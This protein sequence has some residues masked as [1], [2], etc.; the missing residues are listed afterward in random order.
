MSDRDPAGNLTDPVGNLTE[1][2]ERHVTPVAL[3][4]LADGVTAPW[5]FRAAGVTAGLKA[6]GK[7]DVAVVI[8]DQPCTAAAVL[9]TNQVKAAPVVVT[10]D[11]LVSSGGVA[12]A[13]LLN[14]GSANVCCGQPG[15]DLARQAAELTATQIGCAAEQVLVCSTGVIGVPVPATPY[16][17]AIPR[18]V[19]AASPEG[20][21]DAAEAIMTTDLV[22]KEA[23]VHVTDSEG[24]SVTV[25]AMAKG[26]GMIAP[27]MATML[28]VVTTDAPLSAEQAQGLLAD[29]TDSTF[30]RISV[31]GV[32]STNDTIILLA[33]GTAATP[34]DTAGVQ[35]GVTAVLGDLARQMV[36]D[37]EGATR[38][39]EIAV[40]GGTTETDAL[41]V[42]RQVGT[43]SLVKTAL[44]GADPNWG[45]IIAAVGAAPVAIDSTRIRIDLEAGTGADPA[46]YATPGGPGRDAVCVC[47]D[48]MATDV[49]RARAEAV[50]AADHVRVTI[51]L[52]VG[53]AGSSFLTC[54]LTHGYITINA[55]YT[56]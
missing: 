48:G 27:G 46:W 54:D 34:V 52:G 8:A 3:N 4:T 53:T 18:V 22:T 26:S 24:G 28:C 19:A 33:S 41:A 51:D 14:A 6:S 15:L 31:D 32:M 23:A 37:G 7:P 56:T 10:A 49:E 17:D 1:P 50:M 42:A 13:V 36:A 20:G 2:A 55:E 44:A 16:L 5:G 35:A 40:T 30:N 39:A 21:L 43:D 12:Q 25:G 38:T 29:A 47:R 45:R 11:N 9:T